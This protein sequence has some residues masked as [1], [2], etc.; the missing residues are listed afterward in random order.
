MSIAVSSVVK[1]SR[2]LR[3]TVGCMCFGAALIGCILG[4]GQVGNSLLLARV[5][6][7][8][9]CIFLALM[10]A[11]WI[12]RNKKI[13]RIDISGAG[14]IRLTEYQVPEDA[15]PGT[16]RMKG[17]NSGDVVRLMADSTLWPNL[18]LLRL[19]AEDRR[20]SVLP[21]LHDSVTADDFRALSVACRW[22]ALHQPSGESK[23]L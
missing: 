16:D 18:L 8:G 17:P 12:A 4:L 13:R 20:I 19:Q 22:I 21:I 15:V 2:L 6:V 5:S 1:P 14:Q 3:A 23:I 7:A 9:V 10:G 11:N